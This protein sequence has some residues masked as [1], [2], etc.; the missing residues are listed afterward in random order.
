M[1]PGATP[2]ARPAKKAADIHV[3]HC[4]KPG[5]GGLLAYEVDSQN[6]LHL[7]LAW[8]AREGPGYRYFPCPKCGARNILQAL[9]STQGVTQYRI[10]RW[11]PREGRPDL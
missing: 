5:C 11:E 9:R 10:D 7:D 4:L 2:P 1:G 8:T 3:L 6:V